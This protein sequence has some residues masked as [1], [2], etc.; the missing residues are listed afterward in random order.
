AGHELNNPLAVIV[1]RAQLLLVRESDPA[2]I[3]SLRAILTHAQ[4]AHRIRPRL[5]TPAQRAHRILRDLMFFARTPEPRPRFCQVDEIVRNCVRDLRETAEERGVRLVAEARG[6]EAKVWSDP[7]A[8][9][10]VTEIL[11][12]NALEATPKGG[13]VQLTV[14]GSGE[15]LAWT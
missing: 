13:T 11:L 12:R 6:V 4:R 8:L 9:R 10:H 3:R 5:L 2:S 1:G 14:H 15:S 7:D